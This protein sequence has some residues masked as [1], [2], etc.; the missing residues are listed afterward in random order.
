[1]FIRKQMKFALS[2]LVGLA[3]MVFGAIGAQAHC[4]TLDGPVVVAARKALAETNVNL[5]LIWVQKSDEPEIKHAFEKTIA[6][7]RLNAEARELADTFFFETLVRVHR[8]GEG[9]PYTGLKPSG[10]DLGEAIPAADKA[11]ETGRL[12]PVAKQLTDAVHDG[13]HRKFEAVQARKDFARNDVE[14]GRKFVAAYVQFVHY[15]EGIDTAAKR[16]EEHRQEEAHP[17]AHEHH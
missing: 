16:G 3:V 11:I 15:V 4:D 8:A 1:M 14:S 6:V 2:G 10:T 12:V 5:V 9:A 13:L 17:A 7:R